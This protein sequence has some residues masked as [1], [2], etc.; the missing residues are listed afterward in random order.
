[1]WQC[2]WSSPAQMGDVKIACCVRGVVWWCGTHSWWVPIV[3]RVYIMQFNCGNTVDRC[4]SVG[5]GHLDRWMGNV[6][7]KEQEFSSQFEGFG[8]SLQ[9]STQNP[10]TQTITLWN[11]KNQWKRR[12][13][14]DIKRE[15]GKP[16]KIMSTNKSTSLN[17]RWRRLRQYGHH[18]CLFVLN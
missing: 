10:G 6:N 8:S 9:H 17:C 7:L 4:D 1:M 12:R 16:Q 14:L 5:G 3:I 18:A 2:R 15:S 13:W 11:M